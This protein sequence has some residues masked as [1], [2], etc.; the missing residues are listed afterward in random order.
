MPASPPPDV[1][2]E[3]VPPGAPER[4]IGRIL[5]ERYRVLSRLGEG[6]MGTVYLCEHQVL[7]RR[8]A[9]KVLRPE[10]AG[11]AELVERFRNEAIAASRI[12]QENVVEVVDFGTSA[13]DGALYYVM[14]ALEGRN[15][16][17]ILRDEGALPV[18]R[19]LALLEQICRALGAAHAR[20]VVHRDVKPEN[21]LV[22]SREEGEVAKVLDF[23]IS[24][25]PSTPGRGRLTRAGAIIGTPEYM[26]PEQATGAVVDHRADIYAAGVLAYEMLTGG[27]P[28]EGTSDLATIVAAQLRSPEPPS[29]RNAAIPPEV[30]A[31]VLRA[32]ARRPEDRHATMSELAAA[33]AG[34]RGA[35]ARADG[36]R[37]SL[38]VVAA[39]RQSSPRGATVAISERAPS[40][41]P[42]RIALAVAGALACVAAAGFAG[43]RI[44]GGGQATLTATPPATP[45]AE[46]TAVHPEPLD[47]ARDRRSDAAPAAERSRGTTA[48]PIA[49]PAPSPAARSAAR[50]R[51]SPARAAQDLKDPYGTSELKSDPFR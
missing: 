38:R 5:G 40:R 51:G 14:E 23:G 30:D 9:V 3:G 2:R 19:A 6:G 41:R 43:W 31:I 27:L 4:M 16:G 21:V 48:T 33:V 22:L 10:L 11:D 13:P 15:L 47:Q 46:L 35:L 36:L 32:I 26:A 29:A 44:R 28:F 20:G 49:S 39:A 45:P 37:A 25:V 34:V 42:L 8:F 18:P 1:P 50:G 17:V 7:K 12:G 24:H